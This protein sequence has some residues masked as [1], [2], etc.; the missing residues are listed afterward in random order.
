MENEIKL[1]EM[2]LLIDKPTDVSIE[3]LPPPK[4]VSEKV[5]KTMQ[6][7][8]V[9]NNLYGYE[10]LANR[11]M[12]MPDIEKIPLCIPELDELLDGGIQEGEL[13]ILSSPTK[14]GKT[15]LSQTMTFMQGLKKIPTVWFTLEMS[16]QELTR[17]F[18]D[19]EEE[20]KDKFSN[21]PIFYTIDNRALSLKWLRS[22]IIEAKKKHG[23][24]MVYIDHLHFL[25]PLGDSKSNVSFLVGGI[26]RELKR[27]AVELKIPILLIAHTKK[28]EVDKIPDINSMRDSSFIAQE[29]D[30]TLIL[31]RERFKKTRK[32]VDILEN[33]SVYTDRTIL[34]LEANRRNGKTKRMA[35]GMIDGM[36]RPY[37]EYIKRKMAK[38]GEELKG[39]MDKGDDRLLDV[40]DTLDGKSKWDEHLT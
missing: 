28:L 21:V 14:N 10:E 4:G 38:Q 39:N 20:S 9:D 31:W 26:I 27:L 30:F 19:M 3:Q 15:T 33:E 8:M 25:V 18:M 37:E 40:K 2:K 1:D 22:Q 34:S 11:I 23:A 6:G 16:W 5:I 24:K 12:S 29:S 32:N 7:D 36:L 17:K 13:M 35:L